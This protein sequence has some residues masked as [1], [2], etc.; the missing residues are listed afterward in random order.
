MII[1]NRTAELEEDLRREYQEKIEI[2]C[3]AKEKATAISESFLLQ[4]QEK[5]EHEKLV[6]K[7]L[8]QAES[9]Q[10][11]ARV[12]LDLDHELA[13]AKANL[14]EAMREELQGQLNTQN[15][16]VKEDLIKKMYQRIIKKIKEQ[17][18]KK[19]AFKVH[20]WRGARIA[21]C[22]ATLSEIAVRAESSE[23]I[24]EDS[25]GDLLDSYQN[26]IIRIISRHVE[27]NL[28]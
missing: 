28:N 9:N 7:K 18:F 25:I 8:L 27:E 21:G 20:I 4:I 1:Q 12:R 6:T 24:I 22:K 5:I 3:S 16:K 17:G 2:L 23:V 14:A 10:E 11:I 15:K 19:S 13:N 26:E